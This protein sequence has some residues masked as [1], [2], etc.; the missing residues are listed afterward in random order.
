MFQEGVEGFK[1]LPCPLL[2]VSKVI[3]QV[4]YK[5]P[6][7]PV[8]SKFY[9]NR[10]Q[11]TWTFHRP[12]PALLLSMQFLNPPQ[13]KIPQFHELHT[14]HVISCWIAVISKYLESGDYVCGNN[15]RVYHALLKMRFEYTKLLID[16]IPC[17]KTKVGKN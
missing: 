15:F 1:M 16:F 12:I 8:T 5:V 14:G 11:V 7:N 3:N 9:L 4:S 6:H 13:P 17:L 2:L 10:T